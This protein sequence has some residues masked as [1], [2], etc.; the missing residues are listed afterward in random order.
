MALKNLILDNKNWQL[1]ASTED[2][3][4]FAGVAGLSPD[5]K[6]QN[7]FL[8][9][10]DA[11]AG[12]PNIVNMTGAT[13]GGNVIAGLTVPGS[14]AADSVL[15]SS[16]GKYYSTSGTTIAEIG[17][18]SAHA[19]NY[20]KGR[21]E[22]KYFQGDFFATNNGDIVQFENNLTTF[23][24]SW[25]VTTKGKT[26]LSILGP[27]PMEVVEDTLYIADLEKIHTFDGATAVYNQVS[28]PIGYVITAMRVHTDGRYLKVFATDTYNFS[29]DDKSQSK[30]YIFDTVTLEFVNSY[31]LEEQVEGAINSGGICFCTYGDN[32]GY[33]TGSGLKLIRKITLPGSGADPLY[34]P[35]ISILNNTVLFPSKDYANAFG[36]VSGKGDIFF[37]PLS[38]SAG[39]Y[40]HF[41]LPITKIYC[42]VQYEDSQ[43]NHKLGRVDFS[44]CTSLEAQTTKIDAGAKLWIRKVTIYM[45]AM[46]NSSYFTLYNR[47]QDGTVKEIGS[48]SQSV[49]GSITQKTI[50]CNILTDF[51]HPYIS[52]NFNATIKKIHIQYESAE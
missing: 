34:S 14:T 6:G 51:I 45:D 9:K 10:G 16:D 39:S 50:F 46:P 5:I 42:L 20:I 13:L 52:G 18:D 28:L 49:D 26:A 23:D 4:D 25:W 21:V 8:S 15:V 11:I 31:D 29:H 38:I 22:L 37:F 35:A 48:A 24:Y 1:G 7:Y 36:D 44:T 41:L 30:L 17:D 19:A 2:G 27:H 12:Q 32:F 3:S 40:L 33:F 43:G 47:Q